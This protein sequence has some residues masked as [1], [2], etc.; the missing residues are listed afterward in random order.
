MASCIAKTPRSAKS[1]DISWRQAWD[2]AWQ[3]NIDGDDDPGGFGQGLVAGAP[4]VSKHLITAVGLSFYICAREKTVSVGSTLAGPVV[5]ALQVGCRLGPCPGMLWPSRL[6]LL[7]VAESWVGAPSMRRGALFENTRVQGR[8]KITGESAWSKAPVP[9]WRK[10]KDPGPQTS[11]M[12]T[13]SKIDMA[14]AIRVDIFGRKAE[15]GL[16][17]RQ[18]W[19]QTSWPAIYVRRQWGS[20]FP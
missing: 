14:I 20:E 12:P 1:G 18:S 19:M 6:R 4:T 9:H 10:I 8:D 17:A 3:R 2:E 7:V 5:R 15:E 11:M 16:I 13:A